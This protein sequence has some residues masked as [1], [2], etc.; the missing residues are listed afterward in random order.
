MIKIPRLLKLSN[1]FEIHLTLLIDLNEDIIDSLE[2]KI[3]STSIE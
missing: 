1:G 3:I 2:T